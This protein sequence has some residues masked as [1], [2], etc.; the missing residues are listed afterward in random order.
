MLTLY[1]K[2][3]VNKKASSVQNLHIK[4]YTKIEY[5]IINITNVIHYSNLKMALDFLQLFSSRGKFYFSP[6]GI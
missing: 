2:I 5:Q 3:Y 6:P 1:V 4:F